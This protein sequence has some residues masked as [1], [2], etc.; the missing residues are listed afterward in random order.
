MKASSHKHISSVSSIKHSIHPTSHISSVKSSVKPTSQKK[1]ES[2]EIRYNTLYKSLFGSSQKSSQHIPR[3]VERIGS[4][5]PYQQSRELYI[6]TSS[7]S[8]LS[9]QIVEDDSIIPMNEIGP[10]ADLKDYM[11]HP[12]F[13]DAYNLEKEYEDGLNLYPF[14]ILIQ[15]R[16]ADTPEMAMNFADWKPTKAEFEMMVGGG[17]ANTNTNNTKRYKLKDFKRN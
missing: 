4:F 11:E 6:P 16:G 7:Q 10:A 15:N 3:Q 17:E 1:E 2:R 9:S 12:E 8:P 5:L 13:Y 14:H